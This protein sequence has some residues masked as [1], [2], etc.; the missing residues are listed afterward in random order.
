MITS[1]NN[2]IEEA[3]DRIPTRSPIVDFNFDLEQLPSSGLSPTY[4]TEKGD[5]VDR[6][7]TVLT[8][9]A[10]Q[11]VLHNAQVRYAVSAFASTPLSETL[12]YEA[13]SQIG[14]T[15]ARTAK[16]IKT[17]GRTLWPLLAL[18]EVPKELIVPDVR[19]APDLVRRWQEKEK[20]KDVIVATPSLFEDIVEEEASNVGKEPGISRAERL[21]II[22]RIRDARDVKLLSLMAELYDQPL[23][24]EAQSENGLVSHYFES[25]THLVI[26]AQALQ[27]NPTLVD[28]KLWH[29]RKQIKD[30]V[31]SVQ[32]AEQEYILK[33]RKTGLHTDISPR[34]HVDGLTS[35]EEYAVGATFA[36]L[37]TV[38]KGDVSLR[39]E[40][41]LGYVEF[42]DG[43][44]FSLFYKEAM[45]VGNPTTTL[46]SMIAASPYWQNKYSQERTSEQSLADFAENN[47]QGMVAMAHA[48]LV[49]TIAAN[50]YKNKDSKPI[51]S[52]NPDVGY[53]IQGGHKPTL[54][55]IAMDFE[56]FQPI[57]KQEL[58]DAASKSARF[59]MSSL[60]D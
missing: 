41:P 44:Q 55:M 1:I 8:E 7:W 19:N 60:L 31:Y 50:G 54:E 57:G 38:A 4:E 5:P 26:E 25:G 33:E 20:L 24:D 49:E 29:G 10:R 40:Q 6:E 46:A 28:P 27:Q 37:G 45:V 22:R 3:L 43:Y 14:Q 39:F 36:A 23:V 12:P 32:I 58:S 21:L 30:R 56:Y 9:S 59:D 52:D 18:P 51:D 15:D 13:L 17:M 2:R 11:A 47:A 42:V 35:A 16:L 48:L 53:V 34:A